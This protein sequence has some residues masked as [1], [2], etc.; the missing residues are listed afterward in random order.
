MSTSDIIGTKR[1]E[2]PFSINENREKELARPWPGRRKATEQALKQVS[3]AR[4]IMRAGWELE[5]MV[6]SYTEI[7]SAGYRSPATLK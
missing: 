2:W 1:S 6:R 3:K 4:M 7:A 5:R